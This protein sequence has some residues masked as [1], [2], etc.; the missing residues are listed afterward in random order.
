ML[1]S[2]HGRSMRLTTSWGRCAPYSRRAMTQEAEV[3]RIL[4]VD[5]DPA[6]S[7]LLEEWLAEAGCRVVD[8]DPDLLLI[9]LPRP[10]Q[11]GSELVKHLAARYPARPLVA[12]S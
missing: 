5:A 8:H 10:R 7:G 1:I 3:A 12:L 11:A 4:V 2:T 9:D 6:L